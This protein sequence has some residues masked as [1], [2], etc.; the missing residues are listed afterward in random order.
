MRVHPENRSTD[1]TN[2]PLDVWRDVQ[3]AATKL[4]NGVVQSLETYYQNKLLSPMN[5]DLAALE[6]DKGE[7]PLLLGDGHF[8]AETQVPLFNPVSAISLQSQVVYPISDQVCVWKI[9]LLCIFA[10]YSITPSI[11]G[12]APEVICNPC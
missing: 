7:M 12:V 4:W 5:D 2:S 1:S 3:P 6:D 8:A 9:T 10:S 11:S